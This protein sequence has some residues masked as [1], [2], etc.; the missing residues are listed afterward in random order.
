MPT[1]V[2][3]QLCRQVLWDRQLKAF[4]GQCKLAY[5]DD[6]LIG[7]L[8]GTTDCSTFAFDDARKRALKVIPTCTYLQGF[9]RKHPEYADL[10]AA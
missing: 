7:L 2:T 6:R 8:A 3:R 5:S 4:S 10:V 9:L 1:D